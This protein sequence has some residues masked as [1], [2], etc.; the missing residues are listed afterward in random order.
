MKRDTWVYGVVVIWAAIW[1]AT[2]WQQY[3]SSLAYY[4]LLLLPIMAFTWFRQELKAKLAWWLY[5]TAWLTVF[6]GYG[7]LITTLT[8]GNTEIATV[9][10]V[11]CC[12]D[13][14]LE[15]NVYHFK[16][17]S[18][19]NLDAAILLGMVLLTGLG[20]AM[21]VSGIGDP[22]FD[23]NGLL[24][25]GGVF[26]PAKIINSF[27]LFL[28]FWLQFF[29]LWFTGFIIYYL[30]H[31]FLVPRLLKE[32]GIVYY[33]AGAAGTVAILYPVLAQLIIWL[34]FNK[35]FQIVSSQAFDAEN[36][37]AVFAVLIGTLPVIVAI[38][39]F[40]QHSRIASLEKQQVQA[41]LDVLKQQINPHFFFNTLNN[42]Y[43]LS[44]T[45][46]AKTPEVIL[47]L[48]ELMRYVIYEGQ[49]DLV[50]LS[51]EVKYMEDYLHLQKIRMHKYVDVQLDH[52]GYD[53]S[54]QIAPLLLIILIENA[55]KHGVEPA[56]GASFL[57]I[58]LQTKKD[59]V[60]FSC[61]NSVEP[62]GKETEK[63][64]G[65]ENLRRRLELLYPG[66]HTLHTETDGHTFFASLKLQLHAAASPH[67]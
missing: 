65:L 20:S 61:K 64:I 52:E 31:Y 62:S 34:P 35:R 10:I 18:K 9:F 21:A 28:G 47:Q 49:K 12:Q 16:G 27:A 66:S 4:A 36:A 11:C 13:L 22:R 46:S 43:A 60:Y 17:L 41:E 50:T 19:I 63:G 39:W 57:H 23:N 51:A 24:L 7:L 30:N 59:E 58:K 45:R 55:F 1:F 56:E 15:A 25:I 3:L 44:L 53:P 33:A 40:R 2:T 32:R 48:S 38:H 54:L 5:I 14:V 67:H 42:L 29:L 8:G 26:S 6:A 37:W